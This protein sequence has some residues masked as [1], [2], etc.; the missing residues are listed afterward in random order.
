MPITQTTDGNGWGATTLGALGEGPGFRKVRGEI[1]VKEMG[2]NAIVLPPRYQTGIHWHERQEEV[3]FVHSGTITFCF[4]TDA[5][6]Y[7]TVEAPA[8]S[9]V[10]IDAATPRSMRNATTEEATY[11]IFG[12][13]GGFVG[14]D[15]CAPEGTELGRAGGPLDTTEG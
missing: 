10:R 11:V 4:G 2:V 6:P 12:A 7:E 14:R 3:Y 9:F 13:Q 5:E 1:D 15:G 8:G